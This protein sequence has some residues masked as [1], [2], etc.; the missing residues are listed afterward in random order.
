MKKSLAI[1]IAVLVSV[2][3]AVAQHPRAIPITL[4]WTISLPADTYFGSFD[5]FPGPFSELR[6]DH[7]I[8][9]TGIALNFQVLPTS[10]RGGGCDGQVG[11]VSPD[12]STVYAAIPF[13]DLT[14]LTGG[15]FSHHGWSASQDLRHQNIV[16]PAG[17]E[18]WALL[19]PGQPDCTLSRAGNLTVQYE[20]IR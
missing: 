13:S 5:E 4:V 10:S 18:I 3:L 6:V 1:T 2:P 12:L 7:P 11:V 16:V 15:P 17:S 19:A 14:E 20:G 8:R 9:L